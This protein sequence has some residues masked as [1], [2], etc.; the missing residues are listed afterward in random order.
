VALESIRLKSVP[1]GI[2]QEACPRLKR[3]G[4]VEIIILIFRIK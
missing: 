2:G 3:V 1:D 4:G